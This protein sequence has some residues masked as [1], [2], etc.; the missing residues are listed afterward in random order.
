MALDHS[1][2]A[3]TLRREDV[4]WPGAAEPTRAWLTGLHDEWKV[5]ISDM[6]EAE[7]GSAERT[8]WP[9]T[10]ESF[11]RLAGWL[12]LELMK[13][14]AEIGYCRFLYAAR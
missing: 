12:N 4:R 14:A 10:G 6:P 8:R 3:G 1:F 7:L 2:G 9:F 13:N 5:A 11:Y